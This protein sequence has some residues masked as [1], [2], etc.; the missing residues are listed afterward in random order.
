MTC[1]PA[2]ADEEPACARRIIE[3]LGTHAFRRPVTAAETEGLMGL[4]EEGRAEGGFDI[5]V[6]TALQGILASPDFVFRFEATG[7]ETA[8]T[9]WHAAHQRR[10]HWRRGCRSSCGA[11]LRTRS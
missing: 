7:T 4:F 5:G 11:D 1:R 3:E 10:W 2:G 8:G 9:R 6:R